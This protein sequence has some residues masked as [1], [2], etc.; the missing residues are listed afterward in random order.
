M[1]TKALLAATALFLFHCGE[2]QIE[3]DSNV[4]GESD[5]D[6]DSD[7][8]VDADVDAD[9]DTDADADGDTDVDADADTDVDADGDTDVDADGDL[10][11]DGDSDTDGDLEPPTC[12]NGTC[13][14]GETHETCPE[15]C[16]EEPQMSCDPSFDQVLVDDAMDDPLLAFGYIDRYNYAPESTFRLR[17]TSA[18]TYLATIGHLDPTWESSSGDRVVDRVADHLTSVVQPG[19]APNLM[20]GMRNW[21]S[22][23]LGAV[24]ALGR[25]TPAVW[26]QLS[27]DT[28][29]RIDW[30]MRVMTYN[31]A[32]RSHADN[33]CVLCMDMFSGCG[34]TN[35]NQL[36]EPA[37]MSYAYAYFGGAEQ[38][39][40]V[41]AAFDH[42]TMV[43]KMREFE[44][45]AMAEVYDTAAVA[46]ALDSGLD[47]DDCTINPEGVR[48]P[49][50]FNGRIASDNLACPTWTV[51][52]GTV[53]FDPY[54][55][56]RRAEYEWD[57]GAMVVDQSC[58]EDPTA[59]CDERYGY[60]HPDGNPSPHLGEIGMFLEY[61][62][63][64]RS[65]HDYVSKGGVRMGT[66]HLTTLLAMGH[67]R[68]SEPEHREVVDRFQIGLDVWLHRAE[69]GWFDPHI[70]TFQSATIEY[71]GNDYALDLLN[72]MVS[73]GCSFPE[74]TYD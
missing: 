1:R 66:F 24:A 18:I 51:R 69:F 34:G 64:W 56:L 2:Y 48:R 38:V 20:G 32:A 29:D 62:I 49:Y 25:R 46:S 70:C 58:R 65:S 16:D 67:L 44:W 59:E 15:D 39:N 61:N 28:K 36:T 3:E 43:S 53:P 60:I 6:G 8:D 37:Q 23:L 21:T 11:G 33:E 42:A 71:P 73:S 57:L 31:G 68:P 10:D 12:D 22:H 5:A 40:E 47:V 14:L 9:G 4:N 72:N 63:N 74:P 13:E 54:H 7:G 55:I 35:P 52:P 41:L 45:D 50:L 27:D 30:L 17:S 19:H 26:E